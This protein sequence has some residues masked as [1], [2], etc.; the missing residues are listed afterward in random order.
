[1]TAPDFTARIDFRH[2]LI[3]RNGLSFHGFDSLLVADHLE[4]IPDLVDEVERA[5]RNG[6]YA[7]GY[8]AYEA[9]P[10]FDA[11]L[12]VREGVGPLALFGVAKRPHERRATGQG[13]FSFGEWHAAWNRADH[14]VA[15][16]TILQAIRAGETYQ[17]NLTFPLTARFDGSIEACYRHLLES[18]DADF[19]GMISGPE[20]SVLS[21]S[22]ELFFERQGDRLRTRPMKGTRRRGLTLEDDLARAAELASSEKDRAENLMIVDLLRNDLGRIALPGS[23]A[24]D[25]LFDIERYPTVWQMTSTVSARIAP[26]ARLV[27]ILRALF[28][29]GSVTGAPKVNTMRLLSDLESTARGPYCG[30][31]GVVLPGGDCV[32]NVPIRTLL[33]SEDNTRATYPVGSGVVADSVADHEYDECLVKA[34]ILGH[35]PPE[36]FSLFETMGWHPDQGFRH[37][38]RHLAR[39]RDSAAYFGFQFDADEIAGRLATEARPWEAPMRVR[40]LIDRAGEV[41]VEAEPRK[42]SKTHLRLKLAEEPVDSSDPFLYHKTTRREVYDRERARLGEADDAV[43]FNERGEVSETTIANVAFLIGDEWITPPV[44]SGLLPGVM[45]GILLES[46]DLSERVISV[47]DALKASKIRVMNSLRGMISAEWLV[48]VDDGVDDHLPQ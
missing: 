40:L 41:S 12:T 18:Q 20:F 31:F 25:G 34:R 48:S 6:A 19:C 45:R 4:E 3:P 27:E 9:A 17:A 7:V 36:A 42:P 11:A 10:A 1:M 8:L 13:A 24:V 29:C 37:Q 38:R 16:E 26:D 2:A 35:E 32:F 22:P 30:A 47:T 43:L 28:P 15:I 14:G 21:A 23:V 46:G 5:C 39:M 33:L 44:S